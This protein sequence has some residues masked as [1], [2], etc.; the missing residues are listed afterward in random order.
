VVIKKGRAVVAAAGFV[1]L[2]AGFAAAGAV[3]G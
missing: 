1:V 3:K 2:V